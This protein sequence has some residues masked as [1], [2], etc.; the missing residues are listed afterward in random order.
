MEEWS[1]RPAADL[2]LPFRE[3]LRSLRREGG[4]VDPAARAAWWA[5]VKAYLKICHRLVVRGSEHLPRRLPFVMVSNHASH[6]D[7]LILGSA[8]PWFLRERVHPLAAGDTF[9]ESL[10]MSAF[11]AFAMNA[12]PLWRRNCDPRDLE[13]LRRRLVDQP[14]G[15]V[16]FPEGTRSR[17]GRMGP[18]KRGLGMMVAGSDV[19]VIPCRIEGAFEALPP[20]RSWPRLSRLRLTVGAPV[21]PSAW[22]NDRAG[23]AA[24]TASVE[25]RVR[26]M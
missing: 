15:Y 8:L 16:L 2:G 14:C 25:E 10:P 3:R 1:Y 23:W 4:L 13:A 24:L 18:F 20:S 22:P 7:A 19:P 12:L 21:A 9:F 6:L 17:T 11:A 5:A 26:S